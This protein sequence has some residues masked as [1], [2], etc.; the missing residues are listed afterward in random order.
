MSR[1]EPLTIENAPPAAAEI[2]GAIK[3][4]IGMVPNIYGAMAHS[5]AALGAKL[6]FDQAMGESALSPAVKEQLAMVIAG[7][8]A[9]DYCASAHTAIGKGAGVDA[10]ELNKNLSGNASDPKVQALLTLARSIVTDR[11]R[12]SDIELSD[13]RNAGITEAELVEVIAAVAINTF[14]NYFNHIAATEIDFPVVRT[15][16]A[17][18]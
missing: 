3:N 17:V 4:K 11:G 6:A 5:P 10:D 8:N 13:A 14:T 12:I 1:I 2:L 18:S 16:A 7:T 9:C 15:A